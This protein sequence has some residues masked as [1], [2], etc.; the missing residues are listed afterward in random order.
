MRYSKDFE[1]FWKLYPGRTNKRGRVVKQDKLG[2]FREWQKLNGDERKLAMSGHPEQG[3]YTPDARKWLYHARWEDEDM[4]CGSVEKTKLYP[5][6][7][8]I[9]NKREC[10]LP[11]VYRDTSGPYDSYACADHMPEKVKK[12][13]D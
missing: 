11:A 13:Y 7:S 6:K 10:R 1:H 9:C 3:C 4:G 12:L 2:A 8:K 5:I